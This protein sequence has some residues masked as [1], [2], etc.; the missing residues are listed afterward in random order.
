MKFNINT[1]D[2]LDGLTN[3]SRAL[4]VRPVKQIMEGILFDALEDRVVLTCTN[5]SLSIE[6]TLTAEVEERGRLVLPG[7]ILLEIIRKIS[8]PNLTITEQTNSVLI[9]SGSFRASLTAMDADEFPETPRMTPLT[10]LEI[11]QVQLKKMING[12]VFSIAVED[13][14]PILTGCLLEVK[15]HEMCL[16]ALDGYRLA[17]MRADREF[18]V[19]ETGFKAVIPGKVMN[20]MSRIMLDEEENCVLLFSRTH[21]EA[22][23]ANTR[24]TSVLLA[25]EYIDY[26]KIL[27]TAFKTT[28]ILNKDQ[29]QNA[30]D[31]ASLMAREGK[32]N[33]IKMNIREESILVTSAAEIGSISDEFPIQ[34]TGDPMEIAFNARYLQEVIKN[35]EQEEVVMHLNSNV[36][37]CIFTSVEGE[38]Y[39]Y[40]VLPVRIFQ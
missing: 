40:L 6:T 1:Q 26:R 15:P 31:R 7:R 35:L 20:E 24:L 25:G 14:K 13:S 17:L 11:P 33:L 3:V 34:L 23:F 12:V 39:L 4:A 37:P 19:E 16:V 36:S 27:P 30:I 21:M 28:A 32:N 9:R 22:S 29:F 5:G 8:N 18:N 2:L 38:E 10:T